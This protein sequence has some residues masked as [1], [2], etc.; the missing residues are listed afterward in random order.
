MKWR[1]D[2]GQIEVVDDAVAEILRR[3][4]PGERMA[5]VGDM[6][7]F[8]RIW[9]EAAIRSEHPEWDDATVSAAAARRLNGGAV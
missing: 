6:W 4:T 3:K 5:M 7:R 9:V 2:P 1:L 8:A